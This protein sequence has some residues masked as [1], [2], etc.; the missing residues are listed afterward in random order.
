MDYD[1]SVGR[2]SPRYRS[3]VLGIS[4]GNGESDESHSDN[5]DEGIS[6]S[7]ELALY[8]DDDD[9]HNQNE[10]DEDEDDENEDEDE[11]EDEDED[12]SS[13]MDGHSDVEMHVGVV[14]VHGDV[15]D[16]GDDDDDDD[17]GDDDMDESEGAEGNEGDN[18]DESGRFPTW[19]TNVA[20]FEDLP[21]LIN[22]HSRR[23]TLASAPRSRSKSQGPPPPFI[24]KYLEGTAYGALYRRHMVDGQGPQKGV[25]S[26]AKEPTAQ[27]AT[28][29]EHGVQSPRIAPDMFFRTLVQDTWPHYCTPV[30]TMP[31]FVGLRAG[32][33]LGISGQ[34]DDMFVQSTDP[35]SGAAAAGTS[36]LRRSG[37]AGNSGGDGALS[38]RAEPG[39]Y[40]PLAAGAAALDLAHRGGRQPQQRC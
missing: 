26:G 17:A 32:Y 1:M 25:G 8:R 10:D 20:S 9:D 29:A 27:P 35:V 33:G 21:S 36:Q 3:R 14:T 40:S 7:E 30:P 16:V 18:Y 34:A 24:P 39:R 5:A 2:Y 13:L 11:G 38:W 31:P 6:S 12:E 23:R 4:G 28:G 37:R 22:A 19:R 15:N